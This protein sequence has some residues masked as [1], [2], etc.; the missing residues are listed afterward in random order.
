MSCRGFDLPAK[1]VIHTVGPIYEDAE[2][3][4]PELAA[5]HRNSLQL[6]NEKACLASSAAAW[7]GEAVISWQP[8]IAMAR[9]AR[10]VLLVLQP[11]WLPVRAHDMCNKVESTSHGRISFIHFTSPILGDQS[12][13]GICC[14]P[15]PS[16]MV[17]CKTR[18]KDLQGL[19]SIA[20]PAI[21]CGV[22]G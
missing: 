3:S 13:S 8:C 10:N 18:L 14:L 21:S 22:Y 7:C 15:S 12:V 17:Q 11:F 19:K 4:A 5:A 16:V 1:H 6:A 9:L 2:T 20:F